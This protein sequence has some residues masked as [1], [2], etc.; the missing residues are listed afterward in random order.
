MVKLAK[1]GIECTSA[2]ILLQE[3]YE[4]FKKIC[5]NYCVDEDMQLYYI[6]MGSSE[7]E[8][9]HD[10]AL[11]YPFDGDVRDESPKFYVDEA[12]YITF[13]YDK[14]DY[15]RAVAYLINFWYFA[16]DY[17]DWSSDE[18]V[19]CCCGKPGWEL[20]KCTVQTRNY[21]I[22]KSEFRKRK[23]AKLMLGYAVADEV[24]EL[25]LTTK[26]ASADDFREVT[27]KKGIHICYQIAP[28]NIIE[29]FMDENHANLVDVCSNC[30][31]RRY[32]PCNEPFCMSRKLVFQLRGLN[33]TKEMRG[34]VLEEGEDTIDRN[35]ERTLE[36]YYIVNKDTY[37]LLH[38][39]YPRMQFIP[40]FPLEE[41]A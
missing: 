10:L 30:G 35:V 27:T 28:Q 7:Y 3:K 17:E 19:G 20:E 26:H 14:R 2:D 33:R 25:L 32:N 31:M 23:F 18:F 34:P 4:E 41:Q 6:P 39:H 5:A 13:K 12:D 24:R 15:E 37:E 40:I 1:I 16:Y 11:Q 8:F 21:R 22:P 9:A 38:K 36:P 29:G